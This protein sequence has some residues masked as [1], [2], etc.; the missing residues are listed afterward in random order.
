MF[1]LGLGEAADRVFND[2]HRAV[3]DDAEVQCAKAH[4]V[5]AD[6]VGIHARERK[7]HRQRN[8]H[9]GDQGCTDVA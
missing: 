4:Q 8:H 7:Q 1:M 3:N 5:G 9:G 2:Y 6:F